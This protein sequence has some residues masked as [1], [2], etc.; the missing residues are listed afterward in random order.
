[1]PAAGADTG[2]MRHAWGVVFVIACGSGSPSLG[3][4]DARG[5]AAVANDAS[6]D[7]RPDAAPDAC[8]PTTC[9]QIGAACGSAGTDGCG[10]TLSCGACDAPATCSGESTCGIPAAERT[11]SNG[12][13]WEAPAPIPFRPR[14]MFAVSATNVWAV[15][16]RGVIAH[17]DGSGWRNVTAATTQHL[18]GIWMASPN[19]GW[20]VGN[21][22]TLLR[23]N[24]SAWNAVGGQSGDL[25][26]V[27]GTSASNVW[28]VGTITTAR[29]NGSLW[30][31]G[32]TP[33]T[34]DHVYAAPDGQVFATGGGRV[35][36]HTGVAWIAET[37]AP[38][39]LAPLDLYAITGVGNVAYAVGIERAIFSHDELI[40]RWDGQMWTEIEQAG[41]WWFVDAFVDGTAIVGVR[42]DKLVT[43]EGTAAYPAPEPDAYLA[44]AAG[45]G[46]VV[47]TDVGEPFHTG[48]G[49]WRRGA[50]GRYD[51]LRSAARVGDGIWFG[52]GDGLI[53]Y[54]GGF[55]RHAV[56]TTNP[57]VAIAG[58]QRDDVWALDSFGAMFHYDG[59]SWTKSYSPNSADAIHVDATQI[60]IAGAGVYRRSGTTWVNDGAA[61]DVAWRAIAT[62]D[63]DV[64]VGGFKTIPDSSPSA[65]LARRT[66]GTWTSIPAPATQGICA[67][68]VLGP[69][70]IWAVGTNME[71]D[72]VAA[73]GTVS[74]W[75]GQTWTTEKPGAAQL[76]SIVV[77][78]GEVWTTG[79]GS[80]VYR[81][82][83]AGAWTAENVAALGSLRAL[84]DT[85][86][87]LWAAGDHGAI[88]RR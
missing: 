78:A 31:S 7:A 64:F 56:A 60:L 71:G 85:P 12:W 46:L 20:I 26:G 68:A 69:D 43:L 48:A 87:G 62:H 37:P 65:Q 66:A 35:W 25:R 88:V 39:I 42:V 29:W 22:G 53:E 61:T 54:R 36:R 67:L 86:S 6:I 44:R 82:G 32:P 51:D 17:Y 75:N 11:C 59:T 28:I 8:V 40:Y 5:D 23:W 33:T 52:G 77:K 55:V 41:D 70:D 80:A 10:T 63:G 27:H 3:D 24:G 18:N 45:G 14:G 30:V 72:P 9:E 34:L 49:T 13:C 84:V 15:G 4:D 50:F 57:I 83:V 19:D 16:D 81:R 21:G 76:C 79:A 74:H 58:M 38:Q 47:V 2:R 73:V 1:M